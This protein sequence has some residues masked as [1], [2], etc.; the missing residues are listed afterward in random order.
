MGV[1]KTTVDNIEGLVEA[2]L[3][4]PQIP[5]VI[6]PL[7]TAISAELSV[8][9]KYVKEARDYQIMQFYAKKINKIHNLLNEVNK[10]QRELKEIK[11]E[12]I[13]IDLPDKQETSFNINPAGSSW[14]QLSGK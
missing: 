7:I 1:A 6:E 13:Q 4:E 3:Y 12:E 10:L 9:E 11:S 14:L 8:A 5:E 2:E